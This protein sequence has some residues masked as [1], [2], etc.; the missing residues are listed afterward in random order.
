[1]L[2][3][4]VAHWHADA[5][6]A[7]IL[8]PR[9]G[10]V[11]AL[12]QAPGYN[13]NDA[14]RV[15][16]AIQR[17]RAVTDMYEPGSTFK[18]VT[19]AGALSQRIVTPSSTFRLPYSIHVADRVVHDAEYRPTETMTRGADPLALVERRG[20]HDRREARARPS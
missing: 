16:F 4:T 3:E 9:T 1:M 11:L 17:N 5:A 2:R 19:I 6:E 8:D 15:P 13:A 12:A 14:N 10:D 18:L 7:V 20:R